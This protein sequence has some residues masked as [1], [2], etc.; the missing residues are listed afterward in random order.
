MFFTGLGRGLSRRGLVP[1]SEAGFERTGPHSQYLHNHHHQVVGSSVD[2]MEHD[3]FGQHFWPFLL[4]IIAQTLQIIGVGV[5]GLTS[6][7]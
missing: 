4:D 7:G 5:M 3:P 2:L 6:W 1:A